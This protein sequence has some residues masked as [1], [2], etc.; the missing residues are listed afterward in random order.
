MPFARWFSIV[1]TDCGDEGPMAP[2]KQEAK[3]WAVEGHGWKQLRRGTE[4]VEL[5]PDCFRTSTDPNAG[6]GAPAGAA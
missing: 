2:S 1:C 6:H 4:R 5:C 3:V